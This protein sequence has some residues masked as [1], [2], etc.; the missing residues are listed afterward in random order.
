MAHACQSQEH[1]DP[2]LDK[3]SRESDSVVDRARALD[4]DNLVGEVGVEA[5]AGT[6]DVVSGVFF[7]FANVQRGLPETNRKVCEKTKENAGESRHGGGGNDEVEFKLYLLSVD[8]VGQ[9][10][11]RGLTN[12]RNT[13]ST[14]PCLH[15]SL[16]RPAAVHR[17]SRSLT[18]RG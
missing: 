12:H 11:E 7:V 8:Q 16:E 3:H 6:A 4:T 18:R 17:G 15:S 10:L 2:A 5:H 9:R 14:R 1:E 13:L